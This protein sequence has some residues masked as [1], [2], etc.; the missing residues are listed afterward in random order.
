MILG[1]LAPTTGTVRLGGKDIQTM[2]RREI[3]RRMQPVF[4][5]PYS[6]LNSRR[7]IVSIVALP[8]EVQG[9]GSA[10]ERRAKEIAALDNV[11]LPARYADHYTIE[12]SLTVYLRVV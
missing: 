6:S 5:D 10:E 8:L 12:L 3:A 11:G 4:Q 2:P 9:I 1:L 7:R